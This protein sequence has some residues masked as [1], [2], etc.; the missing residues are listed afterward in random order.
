[1]CDSHFYVLKVHK[2]LLQAACSCCHSCI[3]KQ[4]A[5]TCNRQQQPRLRS[6]QLWD[7]LALRE[8]DVF[9]SCMT[10]SGCVRRQRLVGHQIPQV[11][12]ESSRL[13]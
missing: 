2:L 1:M 4:G 12:L 6:E 10:V 3:H 13:I 9:L 5:L 7:E 11:W 8:C